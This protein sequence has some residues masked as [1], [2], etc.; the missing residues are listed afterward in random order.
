MALTSVENVKQ[1]DGPYVKGNDLP[2]MVTETIILR[3]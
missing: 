2:V 1:K 3:I